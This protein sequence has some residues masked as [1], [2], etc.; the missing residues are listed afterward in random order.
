VLMPR[1]RLAL[2]GATTT[3]TVD[4][5]AVE[6]LW[7]AASIASA[8]NNVSSGNILCVC[9]AQRLSIPRLHTNLSAGANARALA[10]IQSSGS[11][12]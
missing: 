7:H 10:F 8:G 4:V 1:L 3:V 5:A 2:D 6:A 11:L 9:A 12:L